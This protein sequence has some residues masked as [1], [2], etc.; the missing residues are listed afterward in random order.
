MEFRLEGS[1][2]LPKPP[3]RV[4]ELLTDPA[5]FAPLLPDV[6]QVEIHGG[7]EFSLQLKMGIAFLKSTARIRMKLAESQP[8]ERAVYTGT[9]TVAGESLSISASF[10]LAGSDSTEVKWAGEAAVGA[11][12]PA[13]VAS[14]ME[15]L[16][17]RSIKT[18]VEAI[19]VAL[20]KESSQP[21]QVIG[22]RM[23]PKG[24]VQNQGSGKY[25]VVIIGGGHNGLTC[26][27]YLAKAGMKVAVVEK[28]DKVGGATATEEFF[29]G[30]FSDPY[31][32]VHIYTQFS[33]A[34]T[35]L[36][37]MKFGLEYIE[38]DPFMFCPYPDGK[39]LM[40][41]KDVDQTAAEISKLNKHDGAAYPKFVNWTL[42]LRELIS[43]L[44][45]TEPPP[46]DQMLSLMKYVDSPE[47][48]AE[49]V[50]STLTSAKQVYDVWFES[51]YVKGALAYWTIQLGLAPSSPGSGLN[52][53]M[54]A[55][56]HKVGCRFPRGGSGMLAVALERSFKHLGGTVYTGSGAKKIVVENGKAVGVEL[57]NGISLR[58]DIVISSIDPKAT[59]LKMI[60]E[61]N[62]TEDV[63]RKV[64]RVKS[65]AVLTTMH[66]PLDGLPDYACYPTGGNPAPCH[67]GCAVI[68]PSS[69]YVDQAYT[70]A[71]QG[72][73][74]KNPTIMMLTHSVLDPTRA[75][76]GKHTMHLAIQN[77]PYDLAD[78][79]HWDKIKD[80]YA[81]HVFDI[82][83]RYMPNFRKIAKGKFVVSPLDLE[84]RLGLPRGCDFYID[85][86]LDQMYGLR[87]M[88]G[89]ANYRTPFQNLYLTGASTHPGG[90]VTTAPGI[91]TA[92]AI[93]HDLK[94]QRI[95]VG[96]A[97]GAE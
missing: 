17:R 8:Y 43:T 9:G 36:E 54:I 41:Y 2:S 47:L 44:S 72:Y 82:V 6:E 75:P 42:G 24:E 94:R 81:E 26:A 91:N 73:P 60:G 84:R 25:D 15:P 97:A 11:N 3:R 53:G 46:L 85:M 14:M 40:F 77:T 20:G 57:L 68:A 63:I 96:L 39:Y 88:P 12:L 34:V 13:A 27:G 22:G 78:G 10:V 89:M 56:F 65:T 21:A 49:F 69:D 38:A 71:A 51:D 35:D 32:T 74:S 28:N 92:N 37:L 61:E 58:A 19:G 45:F 64:K 31:S 1:F 23:G 33:P 16:A 86:S 76:A 83:T 93:L 48:A 87:P 5:Q 90:G 59:F 79:R 66:V 29:P 52:A 62:L 67:H 50:W 70:D 30:H 4:Y 95:P 55:R 18:V 7:G 80:D